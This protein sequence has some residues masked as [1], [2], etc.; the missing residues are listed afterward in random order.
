[1]RFMMESG[2]TKNLCVHFD[3]QERYDFSKTKKLAGET[4]G[5]EDIGET[6]ARTVTNKYNENLINEDGYDFAII[7][8]EATDNDPVDITIHD[9]TVDE[10]FKNTSWNYMNKK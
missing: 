8:R 10:D 7:V 9:N 1:M 4:N 2:Q 6:L 3:T 5:F